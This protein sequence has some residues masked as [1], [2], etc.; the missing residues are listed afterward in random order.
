MTT[1]A[2][3]VTKG[4]V[5]LGGDSCISFGDRVEVVEEPKVWTTRGIAFGAAGPLRG[6]QLLQYC[7][8]VPQLPRKRTNDALAQWLTGP[9]PSAIR[10]CYGTEKDIECDVLIG[11]RGW[12]VV[13]DSDY[14][15]IRPV[16]GIGAVGAGADTAVATLRAGGKRAAAKTRLARALSAATAQGA[17]TRP[18]FRYVQV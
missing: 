6:L 9:L 10:A 17:S 2:G 13:L 11:V 18:W 12:L 8:D 15:W 4:S 16:D 3:I 1:I 7:L 14:S 5:W